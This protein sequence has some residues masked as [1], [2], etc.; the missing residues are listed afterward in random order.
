MR[1]AEVATP[2]V[3][4]L[5]ESNVHN[6][7]REQ[8]ERLVTQLIMFKY[9]ERSYAKVSVLTPVCLHHRAS[10]Q[11]QQHLPQQEKLRALVPAHANLSSGTSPCTRAKA[12]AYSNNQ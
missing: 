10:M 1:V 8:K 7:H 3:V 5:A 2:Q 12:L 11:K 6:I 9:T 4:S